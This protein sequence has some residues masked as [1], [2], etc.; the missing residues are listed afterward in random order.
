M[1]NQIN[2]R[3]SQAKVNY[4]YT[5]Y[6]NG[7]SLVLPQAGDLLF[8]TEGKYGHVMVATE[9]R[10]DETTNKGYVEIIDQ[11]AS[12]QAVRKLDVK[13]TTQGYMVMKNESTPLAGWFRPTETKSSLDDRSTSP[14]A[15][16]AQTTSSSLWSKIKQFFKKYF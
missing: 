14:A 10:F 8:W 7:T 16:K 5:Q 3:L 15:P 13:K 2:E 4:F 9:A 6:N 11:N 1:V 12:R